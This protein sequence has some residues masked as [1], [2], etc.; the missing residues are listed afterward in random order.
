M[1]SQSAHVTPCLPSA[2]VSPPPWDFEHLDCP[3]LRW[4]Q[5]WNVCSSSPVIC[6]VARICSCEVCPADSQG[7][8]WPK[9]FSEA[10]MEKAGQSGLGFSPGHFAAPG[11]FS[12]KPPRYSF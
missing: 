7:G 9:C 4:Q 8:A 12:L 2:H 6:V 10:K 1:G 3:G 5:L 11:W